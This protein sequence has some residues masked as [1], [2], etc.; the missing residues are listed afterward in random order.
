MATA[1]EFREDDISVVVLCVL[2]KVLCLKEGYHSVIFGMGDQHWAV[3]LLHTRLGVH[4]NKAQSWLVEDKLEQ[5][6]KHCVLLKNSAFLSQNTNLQVP[7]N[8]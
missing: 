7:R 8:K 4:A 2:I 6:W 3:E 1:L 5:G